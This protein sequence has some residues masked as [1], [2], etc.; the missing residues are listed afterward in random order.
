[1]IKKKIGY[2][3]V[4][5]IMI[6]TATT[7]TGCTDNSDENDSTQPST[8][9]AQASPLYNDIDNCIKAIAKADKTN[10]L[11]DELKKYPKY[12]VDAN[13][14]GEKGLEKAIK[15]GFYT[16][17][18]AYVIEDIEDVTS[19]YAESIEKEIKEYYD[20]D[21]NIE[22]VAK[23]EVSYRYTN[24]S[25]DRLDDSTFVP[26]TEYYINIDGTWYYGWGLDVNS[27]I[28]SQEEIL[29]E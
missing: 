22:K 20:A 18:T 3:L 13:F 17:D 28:V 16:C 15:D 23:A 1:M 10:A 12:F 4:A 14:D 21:V 6:F 27:E 19:R 7:F 9:A 11:E 2:L 26:T 24:Y 29:G 25:D 5:V 8:T